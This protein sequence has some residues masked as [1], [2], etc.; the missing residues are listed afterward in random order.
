[1]SD[2]IRPTSVEDLAALRA[3]RLDGL[4]AAPEAFG[5]DAES[6]SMRPESAWIERATPDALHC[7]FVAESEAGALVGMAMIFTDGRIKTRHVG[8]IVSV[9]V[10]PEAR[11]QGVGE[12]LIRACLA[13]GRERELARVRLSVVATNAPA[14]AL[15]LRL[16]FSVYGV[17]P[18]VIRLDNRS[19]DELLMSVVL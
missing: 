8:N 9:F 6:E 10:R 13:W 15:Y 7:T 1:M 5:S 17:E 2:N 12:G 18:D 4:R 19:H 11:G 14:I 16:G 3:L